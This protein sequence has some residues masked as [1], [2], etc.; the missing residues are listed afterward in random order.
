M[1]I[2]FKNSIYI[3]EFVAN[4]LSE[5][6]GDGDHTSLEKIPADK[7]S[8]ARLLVKDDGILAGVELAAYIFSVVDPELSLDIYIQDGASI[9]KGQEAF[10]V[11]GS[12]RSILTSERLVLNCMQRL[13]GVA[14]A[15]HHVASIIKDLPTQILDTRKTT[16]GM[17][18]LEKWA[19]S[20]GGGTNHRIG[21]YDMMMIKDNHVDAAGG[22]EPAIQSALAYNKTYGKSLAIEIETRNLA[23]VKEVLRVGNIQ[24]IMLDNFDLET[25]R[26]AVMLINKQYETEASGGITES[27]VRSY[28]LTGVDYISIGA[29][30]HSVKALDLSLKIVK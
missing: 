7:K 2:D 28:A 5:D 12:T 26:E 8:T 6:V 13:S 10:R 18:L 4:A 24:R 19:V 3:K 22:I 11:Y 20:V 25:M 15:T 14:T 9:A 21:L 23:E 17:R 1:N 16:P 27:T 29:I 30:T